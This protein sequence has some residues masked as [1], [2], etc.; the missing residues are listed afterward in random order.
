M[1]DFRETILRKAETCFIRPK[2]IRQKTKVEIGLKYETQHQYVY[3]SPY[4]C[5]F[6]RNRLGNRIK[7]RDIR[8]LVHES[9]YYKDLKVGDSIKIELNG[10]DSLD[11]VAFDRI[12]EL[13]SDVEAKI[14]N[15][16]YSKVFDSFKMYVRQI[17]HSKTHNHIYHGVD[18]NSKVLIEIKVGDSTGIF[19]VKF[20]TAFSSTILKQKLKTL[21]AI[22]I[23]RKG[24]QTKE[25]KDVDDTKNLIERLEEIKCKSLISL[26]RQITSSKQAH[27]KSRRFKKST[28]NS[29]V[30]LCNFLYKD[31]QSMNYSN[32]EKT[33]FK[34]FREFEEE[35]ITT[36]HPR[37]VEE[38]N[39]VMSERLNIIKSRIKDMHV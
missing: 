11:K 30:D 18:F 17:R 39:Q 8:F 29:Y 34:F 36:I 27:N 26:N 5:L 15:I 16:D 32:F 33:C 38:Y 28:F 7:M 4:L 31:F 9:N 24:L 6:H 2:V 1:S 14:L 10:R 12:K 25:S 13:E 37:L 3:D 21:S 23:H 35:Y 20:P 19:T 22:L